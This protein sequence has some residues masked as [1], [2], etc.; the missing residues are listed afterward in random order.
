MFCFVSNHVK[1]K[2]NCVHLFMISWTIQSMEFSRP[3][4]RVSSRSLLQ[5]IFP[6]QGSNPGLPHCRQILYHLSHQGSPGNH[7]IEL[8]VKLLHT[9]KPRNQSDSDIAGKQDLMDCHTGQ[10]HMK[11][12]PSLIFLLCFSTWNL[13]VQETYFE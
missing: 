2:V 9:R 3:E 6:T 5:E 7:G 12:S 10:Q 13:N 8:N 11:A 4:Y 1:V